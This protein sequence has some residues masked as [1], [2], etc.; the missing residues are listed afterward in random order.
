MEHFINMR[1]KVEVET[2]KNK[3]IEEFVLGE[4]NEDEQPTDLV[5]RFNSWCYNTFPEIFQVT[6]ESVDV[7][8][9]YVKLLKE[10]EKR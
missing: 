10:S 9:Q 7:V 4:M 3:R 6:H 1:I 5:E 2:N 8:G